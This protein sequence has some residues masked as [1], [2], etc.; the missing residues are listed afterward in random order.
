MYK[1]ITFT[2]STHVKFNLKSLN[3]V[4]GCISPGASHQSTNS[5][6]L[7]KSALKHLIDILLSYLLLLAKGNI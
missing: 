6:W 3:I 1:H 4:D 5:I 2:Y 7:L